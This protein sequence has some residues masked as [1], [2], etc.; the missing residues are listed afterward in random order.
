MSSFHTSDH[1][2]H[3]QRWFNGLGGGEPKRSGGGGGGAALSKHF[4]RLHCGC[5]V[6][7]PVSCDHGPERVSH[8]Q[9]NF[10]VPFGHAGDIIL[11]EHAT[12]PEFHSRKNSAR[13]QHNGSRGVQRSEF[14]L[15]GGEKEIPELLRWLEKCQQTWKRVKFG[16]LP[17]VASFE[18]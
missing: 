16:F 9:F 8:D 12:V 18:A 14:F 11:S 2:D 10:T 7:S 15:G 13:R 5:D 17:R 1:L 3:I 6:I 4:D